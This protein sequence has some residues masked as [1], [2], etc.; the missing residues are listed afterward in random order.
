MDQFFTSDTLK[1]SDFRRLSQFIENHLGIKMPPTKR[2]MLES[3][4]QKRLRLLKYDTFSQYIDFV[5]SD[6]G[7]QSELYHMID[8]VTTNK[9]DFFREADHFDFL[10]NHWLLQQGSRYNAATP[11]RIWSAGCASGEE[12]YTLMIVMEEF[13]RQHPDFFYSII[14][15]DISLKVLHEAVDAVYEED[16]IANLPIEYKKRYFLKSKNPARRAVR[17]KPELRNKVRFERLNLMDKEYP[18]R[19]AFDIIFCR[20]VIIYFDR[21][22]QEQLVYHLV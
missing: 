22:T 11:C 13:K 17:V 6:E 2:V 15:T 10:L 21:K 12:V 3:R 20:N 5:F 16:K 19:Q 9:T 14:G 18:F 8:A 4:L 1:E 7:L